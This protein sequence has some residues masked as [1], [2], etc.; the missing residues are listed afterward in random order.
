MLLSFLTYTGSLSLIQFGPF[1]Q[2]T[3]L[4]PAMWKHCCRPWGH[5]SEQTKILCPYGAFLSLRLKKDYKYNINIYIVFI[6]NCL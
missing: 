6:Y 4:E 3:F 1:I 2:Q 5:S